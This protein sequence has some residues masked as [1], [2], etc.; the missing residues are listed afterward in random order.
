ME[1]EGVKG[2]GRGGQD[3]NYEI[4]EKSTHHIIL[5]YAETQSWTDKILEQEVACSY[6]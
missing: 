1:I 3:C 4:D 6:S 2:W 5:K